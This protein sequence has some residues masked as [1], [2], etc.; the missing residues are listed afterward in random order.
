MLLYDWSFESVSVE[1]V[2]LSAWDGGA[3]LSIIIRNEGATA[4]TDWGV[5]WDMDAAVTTAWNADIVEVGGL[6]LATPQDGFDVI[7][8]GEAVS[9][10]FNLDTGGDDWVEPVFDFGVLA[11]DTTTDPGTPT[12]PDPTPVPDPDPDPPAS[13]NSPVASQLLDI[14]ILESSSWSTGF[15][16]NI[17]INNPTG[18]DITIDAVQWALSDG[19]TI[20]S[21]WNADIAVVD[22]IASAIPAD[23]Y[24]VVRA[25]ETVSF[26]FNASHPVDTDTT[27]EPMVYVAG[28]DAP[29]T[30]SNPPPVE[31]A[32]PLPDPSFLGLAETDA[33]SV[34]IESLS[35][36]ATG[37]SASLNIANPGQTDI[38]IDQI[39]FAVPDGFTV[40]YAWN[41]TIIVVDGIAM[42]VPN[43][44]LAVVAGGQAVSFGFNA[45][46][47]AGAD[48]T[49]VPVIYVDADLAATLEPAPDIPSLPGSPSEPWDGI[50]AFNPIVGTQTFGPPYTFTDE[51]GLVETA[52]AIQDMGSNIIKIALDPTLYGMSS[53]YQYQPVELLTLNPAFAEVL[54]MDFDHYFF[55][56]DRAGPW[57]DGLGISDAEAALEYQVTYELAAFL[58]QTFEG[59]GKSF[60]I[61]NWESDWQL[62]SWDTTIEDADDGRVAGYIDWINIRQAAID[63]AEADIGSAGVSIYHYIEVNRVEDSQA[64]LERVTDQVLPHVDID[65]VS[66][67]AYDVLLNADNIGKYDQALGDNL[68][69][70][71]AQLT[72]RDDLPFENRVFLGE[73][74]FYLAYVTPEQQY[75]LTIDVMQAAIGW[76]VPFALVWQ[77][78]DTPAYEQLYLIGPDGE[79]TAVYHAIANYDSRLEAWYEDYLLAEGQAPTDAA[80]RTQALLILADLAENPPVDFLEG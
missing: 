53:L 79:P 5:R 41:A 54:A 6:S 67:S 58:L 28:E 42:L 17:L 46:H 4:I 60:Y 15:T 56:L 30:P 48:T 73:F 29:E 8:P 68:D 50:A 32:T 74:G 2:I 21:W 9:F 16:A 35:A 3:T 19:V 18:D 80:L 65:L 62:L 44:D 34:Q 1:P 75:D 71:A 22:G 37:F 23:G 47:P 49:L 51:N 11:T 26:G 70:I 12:E 24:K 57:V 52:K 27:F 77:M 64:G 66:Y 10:G 40:D 55:W 31:P 25:G 43:P 39:R 45:S 78:Y 63:Q 76:G 61:G 33:F 69:Y 7:A 72:P 20:D 36:T 13:G 59:T 14:V 38:P